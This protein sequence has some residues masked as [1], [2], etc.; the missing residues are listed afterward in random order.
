MGTGSRAEKHFSPAPQSR[1]F[2]TSTPSYLLLPQAPHFLK[3]IPPTSSSQNSE[4]FPAT[5]PS[6]PQQIPVPLSP[7]SLFL[8]ASSFLLT[9]SCCLSSSKAFP[10]PPILSSINRAFLPSSSA[11]SFHLPERL[12]LCRPLFISL[13]DLS[14]GPTLYLYLRLRYPLLASP[15]RPAPF[16]VLLKLHLSLCLPM[17]PSLPASLKFFSLHRSDP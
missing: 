1:K 16:P 8:P 7:S 5:G 13:R 15:S 9:S 12:S 17:S 2:P 10:L 4:L 3:P 11:V 6:H 14:E